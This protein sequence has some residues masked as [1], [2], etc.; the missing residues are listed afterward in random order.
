MV[1]PVLA[2]GGGDRHREADEEHTQDRCEQ[3]PLRRGRG[4]EPPREPRRDDRGGAVH[5]RGAVRSVHVD[6]GGEGPQ[7]ARPGGRG[8]GAVH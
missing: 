1:R 5:E 7:P 2:P 6:G 3:G 4:A 8:A